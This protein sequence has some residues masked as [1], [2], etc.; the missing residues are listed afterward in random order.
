MSISWYILFTLSLLLS[1]FTVLILST[2]I[3]SESIEIRN[4]A[5]GDLYVIQIVIKKYKG[6]K[7]ISIAILPNKSSRKKLGWPNWL[8]SFVFYYEQ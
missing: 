2:V 1:L 3:M 4:S 5:P 7:T 6:Y 8:R